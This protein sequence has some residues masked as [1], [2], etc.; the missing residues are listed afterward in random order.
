[1][2]YFNIL[3]QIIVLF[4]IM[5]VGYVAARFKVISQEVN[6]G[7]SKILINITLPF[8]VI[9]SFNFKFSQKMLSSGLILFALTFIVH[10]VLA[11]VSLMLF[12]KC[13]SGK[14]SVLRFMTVFSN[15]G[16]MGYPLAHSVY[17]SEGVF[18][19]AIYNVVFNIF[20]WTVGVML[21]QKEKRKG[22]YK[23]VFKNPGM[24]A[25]FIGM[26][27]FIFS[28]K[29]PFAVSNTISLIGSMT[30]PLSM[31]IIGVSLYDVNLKTA[32]KGIE[33]YGASL[34][35]LVIT[36]LAIYAVLSLL[37]FTG[38]ILG[39]SVLLSAMPAAATTVTFA[40][41]YEGDVESA[42]KIT[43]VTTIL[44]A[45]TLPLIMLLV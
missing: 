18:Y 41:I 15:C 43:V 11:L 33:Y 32:F 25:V 4:L 20:L 24:I 2:Q 6:V 19:T 42:S 22:L 14:K 29:L 31:I 38:I 5:G 9:A 40:Q 21:F 30:A 7:L 1:M 35:R 36:P 26:I 12:R 8:M 28:I 17:G 3:N 39:I 37:G 16:Y 13:D 10:G 45:V 34:M 44:S 27:I 23:K